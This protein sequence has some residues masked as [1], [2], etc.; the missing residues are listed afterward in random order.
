MAGGHKVKRSSATKSTAPQ[1][2]E[3]RGKAFCCSCSN[4]P[5][6]DV[7]RGPVARAGW[8]DL[9]GELHREILRLVPLRDASAARRV[10]R[11]MHNE[12]DEVWRPWGIRATAEDRRD[13]IPKRLV[14]LLL[15]CELNW[16][17]LAVWAFVGS[18]AHHLASLGLW[19]LAGLAADARDL[20]G[21]SWHAA[22]YWFPDQSPLMVAVQARRPVGR[23]QDGEVEWAYALGDEEVARAVRVAV[24]MRADVNR[25]LR[26][27]W[28]LMT[29]CA[30]RGCLGAVKAR[31]SAGAE[32]DVPD[33]NSGWKTAL[34]HAASEGHE[35]VVDALLEAGAS[36]KVGPGGVDH[37]LA[38]V[39]QG[40]P[41]P[42]IVRRLAEAGADVNFCEWPGG[43]PLIT[44]ACGG[45]VAVMAVLVELGADVASTDGHGVVNP[46]GRPPP[47]LPSRTAMHVA[48]TGE[49]VRWLAARGVSVQGDG[50]GDSPLCWACD[51]RRVD[52]IRA[53]IELGADVSYRDAQYGRTP[54]YRAVGFCGEQEAAVEMTQLLLEAGADA[55]A[56]NEIGT[57]PLH[58]VMHAACVDL[59]VDAGADLEARDRE[60]MTLIY[61][62]A[63]EA[64]DV[65]AGVVLRMAHR[66]ADLVNTGGEPGRVMRKV[67][68]LRAKRSRSQAG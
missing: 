41:T 38:A 34:V 68:E 59:L 50:R 20:H 54:L 45:N 26:G 28:P 55:N 44:A 6:A 57:T 48:E 22:S 63:A 17:P 58:W 14:S 60:G 30:V 52:A 10:S 24:A 19:W 31:I 25:R 67:E 11:E 53:L 62:A 13:D 27:A 66:G 35:A 18:H 33:F 3:A 37:T 9:T 61:A 65:R 43:T 4:C 21:M 23:G 16:G 32:V 56:A 42:G 7:Q 64:I 46:S 5:V 36:A 40:H 29:Y 51:Q 49:V 2:G 15:N 1:V 39:C 12:V 8:D 47:P